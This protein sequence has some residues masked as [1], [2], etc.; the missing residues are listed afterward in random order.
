MGLFRGTLSLSL[1][2]YLLGCDDD[3]TVMKPNYNEEGLRIVRRPVKTTNLYRNRDI[4]KN[5]LFFD[6]YSVD[7]DDFML[8]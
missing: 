1:R 8:G 4:A 3:Y 5:H 2:S 7:D 6:T